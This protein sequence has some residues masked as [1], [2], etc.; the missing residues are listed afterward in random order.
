MAISASCLLS[1][2][3]A[4]MDPPAE[5]WQK[6]NSPAIRADIEPLQVARVRLVVERLGG[7]G[8]E[9]VDVVRRV[10]EAY[11]LGIGGE[12]AAYVH[13]PVEGVAD[14]QIVRHT[15]TVRLHR[16]ALAVVSSVR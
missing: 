5:A 11:V 4:P 8:R 16:V 9:E 2:T 15:D 14:D 7:Y 3:A 12:R 10:E 6:P 13:A 1:L